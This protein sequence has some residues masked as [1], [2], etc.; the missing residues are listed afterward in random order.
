VGEV[1]IQGLSVGGS[2]Y[3][4]GSPA[5]GV[6]ERIV[7]RGRWRPV[8]NLPPTQALVLEIRWHRSL[9]AGDSAAWRGLFAGSASAEG[10]ADGAAAGS[11][12]ACG[13]DAVGFLLPTAEA[14]EAARLDEAL[15]RMC[16]ASSDE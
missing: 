5:D 8:E 4:G 2:R 7:P 11:R 13:S 3:S 6:I 12:G 14:V 15:G 10:S 16:S 9:A 1:S